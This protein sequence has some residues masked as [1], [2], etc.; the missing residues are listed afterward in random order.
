MIIA[1]ACILTISSFSQGNESERSEKHRFTFMPSHTYLR[2]DSENNKDWTTL[3]SFGLNYDF[4]IKENMAIGL[5]SDVITESF[6]VSRQE[7]EQILERERPLA[8]IGVFLYKLENGLTPLVGAGIELE[9]EEHLALIHFGLEYGFEI[10][11]G[12][13]FGANVTY[14]LKLDVYNSFALGLSVSKFL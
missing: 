7:D 1:L 11:K 2:V 9:K 14:D 5:H 10:G 8:L 3:A 13:E 4:W 6:I 12:W